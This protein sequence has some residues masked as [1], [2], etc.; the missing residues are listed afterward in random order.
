MKLQVK[1]QLEEER[2]VMQEAQR[3]ADLYKQVRQTLYEAAPALVS[4]GIYFKCPM[5]GPAVLPRKDMDKYIEDF[6][7]SQLPHEPAM[8]AALMIQTLNKVGIL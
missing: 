6:L 5:A 2:R 1:N 7:L 8:T 4:T 3:V